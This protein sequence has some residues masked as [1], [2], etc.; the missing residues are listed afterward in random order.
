MKENYG[1]KKMDFVRYENGIDELYNNMDNFIRNNTFQNKMVIMFGTSKVASMIVY[2]LK[3]NGINVDAI[4][5]NDKKR[6]GEVVFGIRV[7]SPEELL[8]EFKENAMVILAS[9][10][11]D[12]MIKQLEGMGY[13][14]EEHIIKAI[15]LPAVLNDYSFVDRSGLVQ[16]TNA[17]VRESQLK[18]LKRLKHVCEEND[19]RY[20]LAGGTLLGAVRHKG[21]IPWDD[22]IDVFVDI[23]HLKK[24]SDA[25]KDDPDFSFISFV[26]DVDYYDECSLMVDNHTILDTNHFPMQL[27]TGVSIDI[28]PMCAIPDDPKELKDY[29][30][31]VRNMEMD[32]WNKLYDKTECKKASDKLVAYMQSFK[33]EECGMCGSILTRYFLN[34]MY[35][36]SVFADKTEVEFEGELYAAPIGWE[37][38]LKALY[39][40]YMQ[41]PPKEKQIAHHYFHA[42]KKN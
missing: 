24:L 18:V 41:L 4:V 22:D 17:E 19:I 20:W 7:Y 14:Y 31:N 40:D 1:G 2:Y 10:Y 25:L 30:T 21:Y 6:Q 11:Q 32:K 23:H 34:D 5:D 26:D 36:A 42:Y 9:S 27:T 37:T 29:I 16:L 39:G 8:M 15:D 13:H 33:F 38:Y 3:K 28:F 35:D 12:E